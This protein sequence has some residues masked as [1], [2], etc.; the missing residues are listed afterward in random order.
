MHMK[1]SPYIHILYGSSWWL[2]VILQFLLGGNSSILLKTR[3]TTLLTILY[4][5]F[6]PSYQYVFPMQ[7]N[8]Q[9]K[10]CRLLS[11]CRLIYNFF[12]SSTNIFSIRPPI[13]LFFYICISFSTYTHKHYIVL[14]LHTTSYTP[15]Y[16]HYF[17][18]KSLLFH[19]HQSPFHTLTLTFYIHSSAVLT[20]PYALHTYLP[21]IYTHPLIF[22]THIHLFNFHPHPLIILYTITKLLCKS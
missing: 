22:H 8:T 17:P 4:T 21:S 15:K 13:Y 9:E 11:K 6:L 2:S 19:T 5:M 3:K 1:V 14:P 10:Q 7:K 20:H 12:H 16:Q 18:T